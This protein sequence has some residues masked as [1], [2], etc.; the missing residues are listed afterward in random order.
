M[1][2]LDFVSILRPRFAQAAVVGKK[3]NYFALMGTGMP[4]KQFCVACGKRVGPA[5]ISAECMDEPGMRVGNSH[6]ARQQR[7]REGIKQYRPFHDGERRNAP[8]SLTL[9]DQ[10]CVKR[11]GGLATNC[12]V[13]TFPWGNPGEA[14]ASPKARCTGLER[15]AEG[16]W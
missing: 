12:Q 6:F 4:P 5:P 15:P 13:Y 2:N 9:H 3:G 8:T 10:S 7:S 16:L 14:Q 11:R 1:F